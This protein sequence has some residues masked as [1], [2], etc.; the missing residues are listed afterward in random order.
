MRPFQDLHLHENGKL[1]MESNTL[2]AGHSRS[3]PTC[4]LLRP[5]GW[6]RAKDPRWDPIVVF[7]SD[8]PLGYRPITID[9]LHA[10]LSRLTVAACVPADITA[11][12]ELTKNP[13]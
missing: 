11:Q 4:E 7:D 6:V 2:P 1:E 5:V 8:A 9:D 10:D 12:F 13:Y 3:I